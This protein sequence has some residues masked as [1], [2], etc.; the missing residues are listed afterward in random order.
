MSFIR[1]DRLIT[2]FAAIAVLTFALVL[3][4][5][6]PLTAASV[7]DGTHAFAKGNYRSAAKLARS[8]AE[9]GNADAQALLGFM[10]EHGRG[11]PQD[12]ILAAH[13]YTCAA[14]QGHVTAQYSLGLMYDKGHGVEQSDT[15]S[16]KWLTLATAHA[17][18]RAR[19]YYLRIRDA[20]G[21]KLSA[22]QI[23]EAQWLSAHFIPKAPHEYR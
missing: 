8:S 4:A 7:A 15:L 14:E 3:V 6:V 23:A 20:I 5:A 22:A 9:R 21:E 10:Y 2:K 1:K 13:W 18:R 16:Y 17:P 11:V 12:Y 19:E